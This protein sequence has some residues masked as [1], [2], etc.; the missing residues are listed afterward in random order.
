MT[1]H[2]RAADMLAECARE[3]AGLPR[4]LGY[5]FT[6]T[7]KID[8]LIAALRAVAALDELVRENER[9]GLYDDQKPKARETFKPTRVIEVGESFD[10][11]LTALNRAENKGYLPDAIASEWEAFDYSPVH[12]APAP[13]QPRQP[14]SEWIACSEQMPILSEGDDEL[15]VYTWDGESVKADEFGFLFEQ[16][17]GPAV[18]GWVCIGADFLNNLSGTVT[19]WMPRNMPAAPIDRAITGESR[20]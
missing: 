13:A 8:A 17:A 1:L 3:F 19:H 20:E 11:L 2:T 18:G 6:H 16:P 12:A 7:Q 4:S 15:P 10:A 14:L 5:D 9:L